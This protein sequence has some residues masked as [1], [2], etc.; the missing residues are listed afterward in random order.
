[1]MIEP[2]EK[3][4][5]AGQE[6]LFEV[7]P[8]YTID[9]RESLARDVWLAMEKMAGVFAGPQDQLMERINRNGPFAKDA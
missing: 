4:L 9:E 1:M 3:M 6:A 8:E 7:C 2:T 5:R